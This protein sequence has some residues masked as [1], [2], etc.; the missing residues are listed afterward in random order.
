MVGFG[1]SGVKPSASAVTATVAVLYKRR[2][3]EK[4]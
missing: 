2:M 1:V 3:S 4:F